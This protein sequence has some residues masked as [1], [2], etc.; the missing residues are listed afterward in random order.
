MTASPGAR[1]LRNQG[2]LRD[3][4]G[5]ILEVLKA[6]LLDLSTNGN[7][8]TE[9]V[10]ECSQEGCNET[11]SL[12]VNEYE[13]VLSSPTVFAVLPGHETPEVMDTL[14]TNERFSLVEKRVF[15]EPAVTIDPRAA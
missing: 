2:L 4:N 8:E 9:F 15:A 11:V 6:E 10:C 12:T 5:R 7:H 13:A 14:L 1:Q 3:V